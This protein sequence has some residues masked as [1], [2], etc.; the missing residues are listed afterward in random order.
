M[1]KLIACAALLIPP[2]M[3]DRELAPYRYTED[4]ASGQAAGY[5]INRFS[6]WNR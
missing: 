2:A 6:C 5:D 3:A 1:L 4:F